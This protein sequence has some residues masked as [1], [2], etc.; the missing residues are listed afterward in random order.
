MLSEILTITVSQE[1]DQYCAQ[2]G[3]PAGAIAG[4]GNTIAN[5]LHEL[6]DKLEP[7]KQDEQLIPKL[8]IDDEL[9]EKVTR[10]LAIK[11]YT[12]ECEALYKLI[13]TTVEGEP[14]IE[15][16]PYDITGKY[17][18]KEAYTADIKACSYWKMDIKPNLARVA[19][20]K[21]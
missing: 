9:L 12:K 13:R 14:F 11:P 19:L 1:G 8:S 20:V 2:C 16:G 4:F 15:L 10:Y 18:P 3:E 21:R 5:A 17:V 6:A 7:Q